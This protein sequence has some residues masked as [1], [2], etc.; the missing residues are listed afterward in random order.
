MTILLAVVV[1]TAGLFVSIGLASGHAA[2]QTSPTVTPLI[3]AQFEDAELTTGPAFVR[4]VRIALE[5]GAQSPLH[6][7]PGPEVGYLESGSLRVHVEGKTTVRY[8]GSKT[9][10]DATAE[11]GAPAVEAPVTSTGSADY[12]LHSGDQ[13]T[14]FPETKLTFRNT[15][16]K[17][18]VLLAAVVLPAGPDR[19]VGL[20]WVD[21]DPS[22]ED[23][24]GVSPTV[25]GDGVTE[26]LPEGNT[27][28]RVDQVA[29]GGGQ[30]IPASDSLVLYSLE[31]GSL[32]FAVESGSVQV[33]RGV[34]PGARADAEPGTTFSLEAGDAAFFQ[35]GLVEAA[36]SSAQGDINLL[37]VTVEPASGPV[38]ATSPATIA[39]SDPPTPTPEPTVEPTATPRPVEGIQ[40]GTVLVVA[41]DAV[42]VRI[43]P[44]TDAE[45]VVVVAEGTEMTVT[46]PSEEGG[47]YTWWPVSLNDDPTISGYVVNDFVAPKEE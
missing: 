12:I 26:I 9:S 5:P 38:P 33:S 39:I 18:A 13:I 4:L 30:A 32:D 40:E 41:E 37:R 31:N 47:G 46:G 45:I 34:D 22:D 27:M 7:H 23:L 36:R 25:L 24:A 3:E 6:T 16:S 2:L 15:G 10:P 44:S 35:N 20:D 21:E 43:E 11:A 28:L 17:D 19:P 29:L 42:N 1:L 8:A 14:Y